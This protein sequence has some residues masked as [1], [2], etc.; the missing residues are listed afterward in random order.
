MIKEKNFIN[1][2]EEFVIKQLGINFSENKNLATKEQRKEKVKE[3][4]TTDSKSMALIRLN[5]GFQC[6]IHFDAHKSFNIQT[7]QKKRAIVL[8]SKFLSLERQWNVMF[9][10][11]YR[12]YLKFALKS[13]DRRHT[14]ISNSIS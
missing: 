3:T 7:P 8:L 2:N 11:V 10:Q 1:E 4:T 13:Y 6:H 5:M 14:L 12:T 9:A